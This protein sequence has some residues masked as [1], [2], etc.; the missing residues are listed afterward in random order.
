MQFRVF[1]LLSL[2]ALASA[3]VVGRA[4]NPQPSAGSPSYTCPD[5][6]T[7][8]HG[9]VSEL[10]DRPPHGGSL[11]GCTYRT[12]TGTGVHSCTYNSKTGE[13]TGGGSRCPAHAAVT[14]THKK[15]AA[16]SH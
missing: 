1:A 14:S 13:C 4:P 10:C 12:G 16:H 6:N 9:K 3:S 8:S 5:T 11:F 2:A 15:R 7:S